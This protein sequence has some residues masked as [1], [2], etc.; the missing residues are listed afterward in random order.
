MCFLGLKLDL[1]TIIDGLSFQ[2]K[3]TL[4]QLKE[5]GGKTNIANLAKEAE[6]DQ[7]TVM[8]VALALSERGLTKRVDKKVSNAVLLPEGQEYARE[9]LPERRMLVALASC[10]PETIEEITSRA[11]LNEKQKNIALTW[12]KRMGWAEFQKRNDKTILTP[13]EKGGAALSEKTA[14]EILIELLTSGGRNVDE[15][16][17][18]LKEAL[19]TLVNRGL[20]KID[21]EVWR[22]LELTDLGK[23]V[24]EHGVELVEEVSELTHELLVSERWR[25]VKFRRYDVVAPGAPIYPGKVHPQQQVI[26]ELRKILLE[27]GFIEIRGRIVESEFYN[28]DILFQAQDHPSREIHDSLSLSK[29]RQTKLPQLELVRQVAAA[30]EHGVAGSTGW[31]YKFNVDMSLR[32]V[33]CSQTTAAT[34]RYLASHPEPPAKV[35]CVDRTYR[36]EKIDHKHLAEFYQAEGIVMD[37]GLTLCDMLGYLR[38]IISKLGFEKMR[39]RPSV[40]PFTEPSVEADVYHPKRHEWIEILGAGIFRPEVVRPL[41][42]R[43]PVLAWGIG[44]TRLIAIRL[45][46]EDIRDIFRNDLAWISTFVYPIQEK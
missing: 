31:G 35:F 9:G 14:E 4:I 33:L 15:L 28:F 40:F 34:I 20:V 2:E 22:E 39:F 24:L 5:L 30:H 43:Y 7:A 8:R 29:P 23:Q 36:H 37:V 3:K 41:G 21:E 42:I 13:T 10:G 16:S 44:L 11:G 19:Q 45:G 12:L 18:D 26:D 1:R 6:L 32:P 25:G 46:L 27:M 38:Q 17:G